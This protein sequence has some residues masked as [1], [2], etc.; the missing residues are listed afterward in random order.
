MTDKIN[1]RA[2]TEGRPEG[3]ADQYLAEN[4]LKPREY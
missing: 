1:A 4:R 2:F 3:Y